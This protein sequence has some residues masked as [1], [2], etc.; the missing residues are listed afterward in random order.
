M[1]SKRI[2]LT[3]INKI[4]KELSEL[5]PDTRPELD[6]KTNWQLLVATI[7][8]AQCTD[9]RVNEITAT[10]FKVYPVVKNY[11]ALSQKILEKKI[12]AAGFFRNK[13]KNIIA[14]A[15]II[16]KEHKKRVPSTM[17]ELLALPGVAR[18][19]ANIVLF[20]AF[21][22]TEGIAVDTHVKRLSQR[23]GLSVSAE[24]VKIEQDLMRIVP[25]S[26]WGHMNG[27]LVLHGRRI[28]KATRPL[29]LNCNI[30]KYCSYYNNNK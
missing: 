9:K 5:Y 4:I 19:T 26:Q 21:G 8:S 23:L 25:K 16:I 11:A 3:V 13:S 15:K 30:K 14:S 27:L 22:K 20:H 24:P 28:C 6:Y 7:L 2:I 29:C 12:H 18:K 1:K 17:G 10:L